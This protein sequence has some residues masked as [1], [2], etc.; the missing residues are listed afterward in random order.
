MSCSTPVI[1][2]IFRRP[3]VTVQVFEAIRQAQPAKLLV[4]ADG[5]RNEEEALFCQ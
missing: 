1:F 2:L 5:P 4:V 3:D